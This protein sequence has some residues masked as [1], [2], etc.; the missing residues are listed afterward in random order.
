MLLTSASSRPPITVPAPRNVPA[1]PAETGAQLGV[2]RYEVYLHRSVYWCSF[3]AAV[4]DPY[5]GLVYG[6]GL[7]FTATGHST[8]NAVYVETKNMGGGLADLPFHLQVSS[9]C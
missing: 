6:P 2:G 3:V 5:N 4:G 7:V 8:T 9:G 1:P